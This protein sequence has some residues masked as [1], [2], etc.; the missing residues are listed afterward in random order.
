M[1]SR[2]LDLKLDADNNYNRAAKS[3]IPL[4]MEW[5]K[6]YDKRI[7]VRGELTATS[8]QRFEK[9]HSREINNGEPTFNMYGIYM[10]DECD[11]KN[12]FGR[13]G[14]KYHFLEINS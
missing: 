11:L 12:K 6:K 5:A 13:Y 1:T 3:V 2:S 7:C 4:V 14:T 9:N 10:P 8:I